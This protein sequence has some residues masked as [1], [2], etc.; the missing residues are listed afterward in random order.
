[1]MPRKGRANGGTRKNLGSQGRAQLRVRGSAIAGYHKLSR[2][3]NGTL[4]DIY[5]QSD[6]SSKAAMLGI[7]TLKKLAK[8]TNQAFLFL[9]EL[10]VFTGMLLHQSPLQHVLSEHL[11]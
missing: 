7:F 1:M 8:T 5:L 11:S 3:D 2:A 9:R 6:V 10:T 4:L